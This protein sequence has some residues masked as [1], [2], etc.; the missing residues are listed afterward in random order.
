MRTILFLIA[1]TVLYAALPV[2]TTTFEVR[3]TAGADTSGGCFITGGSGT[4]FSQQNAAQ[5][6]FSLGNLNRLNAA[7]NS[8]TVTSDGTPFLSTMVDNCIQVTGGTNFITGF[9]RVVTFNSTS[10]IVVDRAPATAGAGSVGTGALGG[11][12]ATVSAAIAANIGGMTVWAKASGSLTVTTTTTFSTNSVGNNP[13]RIT[14]YTTT[15]GDGG[16]FTWTTATNSTNLATLNGAT[17]LW[18]QN[19]AFTNTAATRGIGIRQTGTES[20]QVM[21]INCSF[22]GMSKAVSAAWTVE[23]SDIRELVIQNSE[24]KNSTT[25]GIEASAFTMVYASYIHDNTGIGLSFN[26]NANGAQVGMIVAFSIIKSNTSTGLNNA[27]T[28]G[29]TGVAQLNVF[30]SDF[31]SNGADGI[32]SANASPNGIQVYNSIFDSNTGF[33]ISLLNSGNQP[34]TCIIVANGF[35]G[36][37]TAANQGIP[38]DCLSGSV[39]LTGTPFTN[40]AGNNF[41]LNNTSGAGAL[42]KGGGYPGVLTIGGTGSMSL[43][44]LQP[45]SGGGATGHGFV[46]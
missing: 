44:P 15:R 11:A 18:F 14:G 2:N 24:V 42:A 37:T 41:A 46:Q 19:I 26:A 33:G 27:Y 32:R 21:V 6:T 39:T 22:D 9:Y 43:G 12:L 7:Q 4:D 3:P 40:A 16:R 34:Q 35:F 8:T 31:V 13:V 1:S 10:S 45:T 29:N 23:S 5:V 25:L 30:N 28:G 38:S 36:N 20:N 17:G